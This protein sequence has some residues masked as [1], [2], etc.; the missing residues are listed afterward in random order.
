MRI[1]SYIKA[2][3]S[4]IGFFTVCGWL[5]TI[6]KEFFG[7][8]W[9]KNL[10]SYLILIV[11]AGWLIW[12]ILYLIIGTLKAKLGKLLIPEMIVLPRGS[13]LMGSLRDESGRN[14][15]EGPQHKVEIDYDLAV[16]VH[17]VTFVVDFH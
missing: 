7:E 3:L 17:P 14:E 15:N 1:V 16:G 2:G 8:F 6:L 12:G 10:F 9:I 5:N 4:I 11:I 13:L